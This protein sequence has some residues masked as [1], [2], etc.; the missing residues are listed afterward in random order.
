MYQEQKVGNLDRGTS[1]ETSK[2]VC[3]IDIDFSMTI[4]IQPFIWWFCDILLHFILFFDTNHAR[5]NL[6]TC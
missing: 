5:K 3:N 1:S 2:Q 6:M 4:Y